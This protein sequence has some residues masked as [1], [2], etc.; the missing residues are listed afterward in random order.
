MKKFF[1]FASII[2]AVAM[3][4]SCDKKGDAPKARFD[5]AIED[6][7]V[8]FT[9]M[10]KEAETYAW[11]FGDG[12]TSTEKDPV[13]TYAAA[14]TYT[15]KLT[16]KNKAGE[17]STEQSIVLEKKAW[18]VKIDG[19]FDDWG[20]VPS[21]VLATAVADENSKYEMLYAIKFCTDA[22]YIY[23]YVEF[24]AATGTYIDDETGEPFDGFVVDYTDMYFNLDD[25]ETT[26]SNS[27]LWV[28]S[29]AEFLI[30]GSIREYT[31]AGL[32][33]FNN[34]DQSAWG[35]EDTGVAGIINAASEAVKLTNGHEA[36]EGKIMRA[37]FPQ[38]P[39]VC[40]VGVFCSDSGWTE[41][42]CLPQVTITDE[43]GEEPSPLLE[44]KLN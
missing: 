19:N 36:V 12:Q 31:G 27:Y 37:M 11:D 23:F 25:D 6:L 15:V 30:E 1:V 34:P 43:G 24:D 40:K 7:T 21:D 29:A 22:D 28:N 5:Y 38:T 26:G 10:S 14:G 32:F 9:N 17:N 33:F 44:V 2:A 16:A 39:K 35:W 20:K 18:E 42:G 41:Q 4:A 3:F 13:H 8:T